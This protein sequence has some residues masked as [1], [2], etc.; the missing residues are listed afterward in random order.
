[1]TFDL[2]RNHTHYNLNISKIHAGSQ[3][4]SVFFMTLDLISLLVTF[5]LNLTNYFEQYL[6]QLQ[7][8]PIY[9]FLIDF[10]SEL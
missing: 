9:I 7:L 1:M 3:D 8:D 2:V 5:Q 10:S 4:L 6:N